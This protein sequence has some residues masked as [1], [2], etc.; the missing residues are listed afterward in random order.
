MSITTN[1]LRSNC[2]K[3]W[4]SQQCYRNVSKGKSNS[5][6]DAKRFKSSPWTPRFYIQPKILKQGNSVMSQGKPVISSITITYQIFLGVYI[7]SYKW[8]FNIC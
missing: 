7:I 8:Q 6:S 3:Q 2:S 4:T 5:K 1:Y